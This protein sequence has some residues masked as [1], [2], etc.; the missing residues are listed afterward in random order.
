MVISCWTSLTNQVLK[1]VASKTLP[2]RLGSCLEPSW[3]LLDCLLELL[4][5][6]LGSILV[7]SLCSLE[8]SKSVLERLG[9]AWAAK[10]ILYCVFVSIL[11]WQNGRF[12]DPKWIKK[13]IRI[14]I[15]ILLVFRNDFE[16]IFDSFLSYT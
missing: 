2:R 14:A 16:S 7:R 8:A 5:H 12:W 13:L 1:R 10:A 4:E 15:Q 9:E 3:S 11:E 6:V